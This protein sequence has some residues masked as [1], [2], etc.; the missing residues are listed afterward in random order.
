MPVTLRPVRL[1]GAREYS[2]ALS[3]VNPRENP[4]PARRA[5]RR[6]AE[7][8]KKTVRERYLRG[9]SPRRLER[10]SGRLE[11]SVTIDG[12]RLPHAIEI[13]VDADLWWAENYE[14]G[15]GPRG[16]RPFMR[17]TVRDVLPDAQRIVLDE[18]GRSVE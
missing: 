3:R 5:L 18:W 14:L 1:T 8:T 13:G 12:S 16:K 15:R 17:P 9:P 6:I 7:L 11:S 2:A 10:R 4:V